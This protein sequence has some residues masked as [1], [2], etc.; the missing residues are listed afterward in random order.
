MGGR[1]YDVNFESLEQTV[2][3]VDQVKGCE[4]RF[5]SQSVVHL[6]KQRSYC[7]H[8]EQQEHFHT[9]SQFR[10]TVPMLHRREEARDPCQWGEGGAQ[11]PITEL[12]L[13]YS[14]ETV[15]GS[16]RSR[17]SVSTHL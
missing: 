11:W 15:A 8:I 12:H 1:T 16:S 5:L 13:R 14:A 2:C 9:I 10:T 3:T 6:H 17:P 4:Q 7:A